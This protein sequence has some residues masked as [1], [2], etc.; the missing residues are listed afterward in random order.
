MVACVG[1]DLTL[2]PLSS[3][4]AVPRLVPDKRLAELTWFLA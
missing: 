2:V 3:A 4:V 1:T